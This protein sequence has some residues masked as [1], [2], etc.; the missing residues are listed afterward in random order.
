MV[1]ATLV[2]TAGHALAEE[3]RRLAAERFQ[4]GESAALQG[5]HRGAAL[6][7]EASYDVVPT[8]EA[9]YNAAREWEAAGESGRAADDYEIAVEKTDLHGPQLADAKNRLLY[10][11]RVVGVVIVTGP[12][13]LKVSLAHAVDV[14]VPAR[15]HVLP[16]EHEVRGQD[17]TGQGRPQVMR[18]SAG[19]TVTVQMPPAIVRSPVLAGTSPITPRDSAGHALRI[20][21]WSSLAGAAAF[22]GGSVALYF[23]AKSER[24]DFVD[25]SDSS[26]SLHGTATAWRTATYTC[27]GAAGVAAVAGVAL[28]VI[29]AATEPSAG[30]RPAMGARAWS[31]RF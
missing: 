8:A 2:S 29:A 9:A 6:S 20:A 11:Q 28:L 26:A 17:P 12:P 24:D 3:P 23:K 31:I 18:V 15:V 13:G 1:T 10:L 5:N 19:Q 30:L 22:A 21:G 4:N 14:P 16:G 27:Y 25:T 7:Y